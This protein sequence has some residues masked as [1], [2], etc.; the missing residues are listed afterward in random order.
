[1]AAPYL[2][3]CTKVVHSE[4]RNS[5]KFDSDTSPLGELDKWT[6]ALPSSLIDQVLKIEK[7]I[8]DAAC[9]MTKEHVAGQ[10]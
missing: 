3:H 1:M 6:N 2:Q 7:E 8:T 4:L 9:Q 10:G 5:F